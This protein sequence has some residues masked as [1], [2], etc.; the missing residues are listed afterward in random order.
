MQ[1]RRF[2][3]GLCAILLLA[4][5]AI[6]QVSNN[7]TAGDIVRAL[8]PKLK[9]PAVRGLGAPNRGITVEGGDT[10]SPPPSIDLQVNFEFDS[11]NLT[12]DARLTLKVLGE[13]LK[14]KELESLRFRITGHTDSKGT[15]EY[16][17]D[18]SKRRAEAVRSHLVQFYA[19]AA[20]RLEADGKGKTQLIDPSHPENGINRRV[21][22]QTLGSQIS[23]R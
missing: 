17:L 23:G 5:P 3:I 4:M 13:A 16:N 10:T 18:L 1:A 15:A 8:T 19:I 20:A 11:S 2:M 12:N 7:P 6:A 22:I 14:A 21:Q 9:K